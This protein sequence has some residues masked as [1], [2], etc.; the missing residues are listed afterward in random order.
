[1]QEQMFQKFTTSRAS[2]DIL[3]LTW[4]EKLV[5]C[6]EWVNSGIS[7]QEFCQKKGLATGT[8]HGWCV[9]RWP[10][11]SKLNL[12]PVSVANTANISCKS[13]PILVE[14]SF[15]NKVSA[16]ITATDNQFSFLFRELCHAITTTR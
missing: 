7:K 14:L 16:R 3:K 9:R 6:D 15:P 12:Y 13:E 10:N 8:F 11:K 2:P 1:M 5:I 4:S